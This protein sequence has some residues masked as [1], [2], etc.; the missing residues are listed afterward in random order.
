MVT[1][2]LPLFAGTFGHFQCRYHIGPGRN[3]HEQSFFF[4][5]TPGHGERIV[6]GHLDAFHNLRIALAVLQMEV[7]RNEACASSLNLVRDRA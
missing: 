1:I 7:F 6:I 5:Q 4:G 3:A 2:I